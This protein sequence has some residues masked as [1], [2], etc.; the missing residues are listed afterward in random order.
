VDASPNTLEEVAR[1]EEVTL[2]LSVIVPARNEEANL[3]VC[4]DTLLAQDDEFFALGCDWELLVI[5]DG[6]IDPTLKIAQEALAGRPGTQVLS[7]P[8]LELKG[9][10]RA[11][12]GKTNACWAGAQAVAG[13]WLLFTDADT[14]HEPGS[15]VRAIHEAERHHAALLSYSPRQIVSGFWQRALMPLIFSELASV[16]PPQQVN[17]PAH[18][19][20]AANGQF[21]LI[22]REAYFAVGGHRMVGRSVLE[23]VDLSANVKRSKRDIRFRYAPD[24]L[25]TRMYRG[26]GDMMEGWSKNLFLLFPHALTLAAWRL[27]DIV[28]LLLPVLF[29]TD[30]HLILWQQG[31]IIA[32]WIR[33]LWRFYQRVARSNFGALDCA[34]SV[35]ALPLFLYVLVRSWAQHKLFHRIVWK[36]RVYTSGR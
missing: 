30:T 8:P 29:F 6:S 11:F 31:A 10:Q 35:F 26:F 25:S 9:T 2:T 21:L 20:A 33:T 7:A 13:K 32:I 34:I 3:R 36:G 14:L 16:Y 12:T 1:L 24:A 22:T 28:L 19:L 18:R 17:D 4:L 27:L 23:D 15:L 5:D